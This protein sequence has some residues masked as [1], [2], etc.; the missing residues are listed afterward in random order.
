MTKLA[1]AKITDN[2][3]P[4]R[5]HCEMLHGLA[6]SVDGVFVVSAFNANLKGDKGT[7]THHRVGDVDG[8]VEAILAHQ[9]TPGANVYTAPHIMK[10]G[11]PRGKRGTKAD[12]VVV[13][14]LTGAMAESG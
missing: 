10:R 8:M 2:T 7:I 4:I 11:L 14:G 9:D 1:A 6:K 5:T 13:V 3:D 12:I